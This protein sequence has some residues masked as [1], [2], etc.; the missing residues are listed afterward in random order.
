M[1]I[2]KKIFGKKEDAVTSYADFWKWFQQ[3]EKDFFKVVKDQGDLDGLFFDK[4]SP[5]LG[6]LKDGFY[7]LTGMLNKNT[8]ELIL[9][10]D[11][12]IKNIPFVEDLVESS[13]NINGWVFTALKPASDIK[14]VSINMAGYKFNKENITFYANNNVDFPDEIAITIVYDNFNEVD[15]STIT[16][17]IYLFLDN[18]LGELNSV[19][20]IDSLRIIGK[21][22][23][24]KEELIPIEKLKDYLIW[25][26]KEFIEKYEGIRHN[27]ENDNYSSLESELKNGRPLIGVFNTSLLEWDNK[28]SH[29]WILNV[30]IKYDGEKNNGLPD[31]HTYELLDK[32][33]RE[34]SAELKDSDGYLNIGRQSADNLRDIYFA[35]KDFRKPSRVVFNIEQN[36]ANK[37]SLSYDIYKDKYWHTFDRFMN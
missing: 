19:T 15:T 29:P 27:T 7:Y 5:K 2:L 14:N 18:F 8:V 34:I 9:T 32:I 28:A 13:P 22:E 31:K 35:C 37:L 17:G 25:R 33:E 26:Q 21:S 30:E 3:K 23:D 16:N 20:T 11:G 1:S 4:L 24:L 36:Y 12:T 10:A 6:E